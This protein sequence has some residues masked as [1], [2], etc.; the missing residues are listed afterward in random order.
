[1]QANK[2]NSFV[3]FLAYGP[4]YAPYNSAPR[5]YRDMYEGMDIKLRPNVLENKGETAIAA[6]RGYYAHMLALD[7]CVAELQTGIKNLGL[8]ENSIFVFSSNHGDIL[9]SHGQIKN[10]KPWEESI[11]VPFILKYP[12]KLKGGEQLTKVE[13]E[14]GN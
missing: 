10:Q 11:L 6:I 5:K 4:T 12:Y 2:D 1:M 8:D 13:E 14:N 7:D 9:Y 3:L